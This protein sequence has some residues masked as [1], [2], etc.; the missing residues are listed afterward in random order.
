MAIPGEGIEKHWR[1][2]ISEVSQM[3]NSKHGTDYRIFNLTGEE[4]AL[5]LSYYC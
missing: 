2:N 1:N 4:C 5:P 3:L